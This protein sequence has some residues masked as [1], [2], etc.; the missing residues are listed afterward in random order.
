MISVIKN[1]A[2]GSEMTDGVAS[3]SVIICAEAE[4]PVRNRMYKTEI[5]FFH[6]CLFKSYVAKIQGG[7]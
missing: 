2:P 6:I 1:E 4:D 3:V 7:H 5:D